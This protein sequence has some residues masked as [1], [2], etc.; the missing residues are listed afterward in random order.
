MIQRNWRGATRLLMPVMFGVTAIAFVSAA[1]QTPS[2]PAAQKAGTGT[3]AAAALVKRGEYLVKNHG[4][5]DCHTPQKMG[6]NGPEPDQARYLSG[7][8]ADLKLPPPPKAE[9]P[10]IVSADASGTAWSGP[11]GISY[12]ANLTPDP[13]TGL[14]S[15]TEQQFIEALRTGR[16]QGRGR[17]ILPPMP[18]QPF[19]TMTDADLKAV[20]AYL[21]SITPVKNKVPDPVIAEPGK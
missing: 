20:F 14:G 17:Q 21:H 1:D 9:G 10:W 13:E 18:W 7:H 15:W 16:H 12:T 19:G 11:W 4:C 2:R 8:P 5:T 6:A 3:P